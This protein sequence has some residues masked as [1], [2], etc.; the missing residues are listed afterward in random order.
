MPVEA[1]PAVRLDG[2]SFAYRPGQPV[3]TDVD[4]R[5]DEGE[6]VAVAA[7]ARRRS[8]GSSSA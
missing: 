3:L 2:V 4:L 7:A 5:V 8:S 1:E 6:F